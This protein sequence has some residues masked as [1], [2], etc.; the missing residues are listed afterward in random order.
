MRGLPWVGSQQKEA[1]AALTLPA[2]H[3]TQSPP[4]TLPS[5]SLHVPASHLVHSAAPA[6]SSYDPP[7]HTVLVAELAP[8]V[9]PASQG[10][11]SPPLTLPSASH[12]P[13]SQPTHSAAPADPII[14][15]LGHAVHVA[16][17]NY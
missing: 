14:L 15:P 12:V 10:K 6:A 17:V 5:A 16:A 2:W 7:G 1:P 9:F 3:G 8:L 13:A 4:L 11:Q